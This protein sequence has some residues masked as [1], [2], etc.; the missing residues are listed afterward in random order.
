MGGCLERESNN[1]IKGKSNIK[2]TKGEK[3]ND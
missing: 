3:A 2:V 1:N